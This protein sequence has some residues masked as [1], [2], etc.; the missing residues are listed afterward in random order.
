MLRGKMYKMS[1]TLDEQSEDTEQDV[2]EDHQCEC[3]SCGYYPL[4]HFQNC[5][6]CNSGAYHTYNPRFV[7]QMEIKLSEKA[8]EELDEIEAM[9]R[10]N[11]T[12][13]QWELFSTARG[14]VPIDEY[15]KLEKEAGNDI[16][17]RHSRPEDSRK[18]EGNNGK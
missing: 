1:E 18:L 2:P 13:E 12:D 4:G 8:K 7:N 3:E 14:V 17:A 9:I 16:M 6:K 10:G 5:P 15:L 11:M